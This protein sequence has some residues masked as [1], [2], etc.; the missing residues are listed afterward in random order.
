MS[1]IPMPSAAASSITRL[2]SGSMCS[3]RWSMVA[4][5]RPMRKE[6]NRSVTSGYDNR[7]LLGLRAAAELGQVLDA[8]A[9][10]VLRVRVHQGVGKLGH[11]LRREVDARHDD[12]RDL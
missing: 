12:A 3:M 4:Q 9:G 5:A 6:G 7:L 11:E 2:R 8:L 1:S 10:A